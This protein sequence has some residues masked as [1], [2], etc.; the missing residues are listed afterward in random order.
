MNQGSVL[1]RFHTCTR[2]DIRA[3]CCP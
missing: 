2:H 3:H 1:S